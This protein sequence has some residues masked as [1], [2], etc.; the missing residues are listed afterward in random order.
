MQL[1]ACLSAIL[2]VVYRCNFAM[3]DV[4]AS[5][6]SMLQHNNSTRQARTDAKIAAADKA[7]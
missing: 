2:G 6:V 7:S 5:G 4:Y 1:Y 3:D